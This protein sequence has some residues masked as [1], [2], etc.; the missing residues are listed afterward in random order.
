MTS[1]SHETLLSALI[2]AEL[3]G[4]D[5]Q[6]QVVVSSSR[7]FGHQIH[8][9]K[10]SEKPVRV[11]FSEQDTRQLADVAADIA[12]SIVYILMEQ[13]N[14]YELRRS[15]TATQ[16]S[17]KRARKVKFED[18]RPTDKR[19]AKRAEKKKIRRM[20]RLTAEML[21]EAQRAALEGEN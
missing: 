1:A 12:A 10:E 2:F 20:A 11:L 4:Y 14:R 16:R 18:D 13:E 8:V 15:Q 9:P 5:R 21:G 3:M 19:A 17:G 7:M 6:R